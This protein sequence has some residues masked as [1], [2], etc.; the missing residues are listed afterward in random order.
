[1]LDIDAGGTQAPRPMLRIA[2]DYIS[3]RNRM[4]LN[5]IR[6]KGG[7]D[8]IDPI[9]RNRVSISGVFGCSGWSGLSI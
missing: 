9:D 5:R 2:F 7:L 6:I 8:L 1:M 4:W 3:E